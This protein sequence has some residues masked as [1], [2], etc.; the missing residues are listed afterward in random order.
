MY[1]VS[2]KLSCAGFKGGDSKK[3]GEFLHIRHILAKF[4]VPSAY[5]SDS[6]AF[7]LE[8]PC[9]P[10]FNFWSNSCKKWKIRIVLSFL[11]ILIFFHEIF[12]E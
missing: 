5:T 9:E 7:F 3:E 12:T 2:P 1:G 4:Q 11:Q 10:K 6:M 8:G